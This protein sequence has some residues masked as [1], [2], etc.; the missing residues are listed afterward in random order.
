MPPPT[1]KLLQTSIIFPTGRG[2]LPPPFCRADRAGLPAAWDAKVSAPP[3]PSVD[4]QPQPAK[5]PRSSAVPLVPWGAPSCTRLCKTFPCIVMGQ[6]TDPPHSPLEQAMPRTT[7]SQK[8]GGAAAR[9]DERPSAEEESPVLA[10]VPKPL[11]TLLTWISPLSHSPPPA[12][13]R[14][15]PFSPYSLLLAVPP[16][17]TSLCSTSHPPPPTPNAGHSSEPIRAGQHPAARRHQA[18]SHSS[19]GQE[20]GGRR[21]LQ[22]Q[23][24]ETRAQGIHGAG[25][26]DCWFCSSVI[27][28]VISCPPVG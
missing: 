26:C 28:L 2:G 21:H 17:H 14:S 18:R 7:Q 22:E 23:E 1:K 5:A 4:P 6:S 10:E 11:P 25:A 15:S 12:S 27:L 24:L 20:R 9:G 3:P 16:P 8:A 19:I 13:T